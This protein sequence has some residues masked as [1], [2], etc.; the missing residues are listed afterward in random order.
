M[1]NKLWIILGI[2]LTLMIASA[3][4]LIQPDFLYIKKNPYKK[5]IN[6]WIGLF[7]LLILFL[8][9]ILIG[10]IVSLMRTL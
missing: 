7:F 6:R 1:L 8:W 5:T 10:I 9:S 3:I 2:E 4:F